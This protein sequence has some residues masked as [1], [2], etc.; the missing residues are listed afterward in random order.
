MEQREHREGERNGRAPA[1]APFLTGMRLGRAKALSTL[2]VVVA[3]SQIITGEAVLMSGHGAG[4]DVQAAAAAD[5]TPNNLVAR[6][7]NDFAIDL[8]R[9]LAGEM[10]DDNLFFSP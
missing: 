5:P 9:Q 8:Y 3:L 4:F 2:G 1:E 10:A 7:N 6:A